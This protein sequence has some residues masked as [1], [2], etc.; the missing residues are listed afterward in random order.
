MLF[1]TDPVE[2][3]QYLSICGMRLKPRTRD[4]VTVLYDPSNVD[5]YVALQ[6]EADIRVSVVQ[7]VRNTEFDI[8]IASSRGISQ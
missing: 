5:M 6:Y 2:A 1:K 4:Y 8:T 3:L 7:I